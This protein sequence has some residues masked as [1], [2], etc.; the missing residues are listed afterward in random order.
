MQVIAVDKFSKVDS[1]YDVVL[2]QN[3]IIEENVN[4]VKELIKIEHK[5]LMTMLVPGYILSKNYFPFMCSLENLVL[6]E[7]YSKEFHER[8]QSK[9]F[10]TGRRS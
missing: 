10:L 3:C 1:Q 5:H 6:S 4:L 8:I 9:R 2:L 7:F